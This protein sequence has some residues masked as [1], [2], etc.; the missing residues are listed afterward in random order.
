MPSPQ[1]KFLLPVFLCFLCL[2]LSAQSASWQDSLKKIDAIFAQ[3]ST[4][5]P[6]GALT[7]VRQGQTLYNRA[8]GMAD[9]EH[10]IPNTPETVF[11]AG[12][13]SKQFTA[14]AIL[15]LV[16]DGKLSLDDDIRKY[17]PEIPN[18]GSLIKIRH[19]MNHTSGLRDWGSVAG[20]SGWPRGRRTYT[21]AHALEILSRQKSLNFPPGDQYNYC[22]SGYNLMAIIVDRVS[23]MAFADFCQQRIFG[24]LGM[25]NTQWRD[26]YRKIVP[27][28]AIAYSGYPHYLQNMPFEM[29][30][31]N[32]GLLTTTGDLMIWNQNY[33]SQQIGGRPLAEQQQVRGVLNHGITIGYAAGLNIGAYNGVKEISHSGATAGYRAW[34]AYYPEKD[35]SIAFLS[36]TANAN[37]VFIGAEVAKVFF[38]ERQSNAPML[39]TI[40]PDEAALQAKAGLYR[41][42]RSDDVFVEL[43]V[44]DGLLKT[45]GGQVLQATG[46]NVFYQGSS[47]LEFAG[48]KYIQHSAN[49]DT[50]TFAKKAAYQPTEVQLQSLVGLY[51]SDEADATYEIRLKNGAL[52]SFLKPDITEKLTPYYQ[53][54]FKNGDGELLEFYFNKKGKP[55]GFKFTT[56]RAWHIDFVRVEKSKKGG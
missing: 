29:V 22:N 19:L 17:V 21:H 28:R 9:L 54:T 37:P 27:N 48:Q 50:V 45:K 3:W 4:N 34:L 46:E 8:F 13:V 33:K 40:V 52:E 23:G 11:E 10:N 55:L 42:V 32:G 41:S 12:S 20:V 1:F 5:A 43:E 38:G 18:Y 47:R 26:D 14:A 30:H 36:N 2:N 56:G 39:G 7:V 15:L 16:Q 53:H 31:G 24:P 51:R 35:L 44:K 25:K 6:G 49:G